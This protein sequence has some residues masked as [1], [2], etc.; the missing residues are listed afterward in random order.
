MVRVCGAA[1]TPCIIMNR[2]ANDHRRDT[3][4]LTDLRDLIE[5]EGALP[6]SRYMTL[7]LTHAQHGYYSTQRAI[8]AEGDFVTA[9]EISQIFGELIGLWAAVVWQ[10]MGAP[11]PLRLIELGPGR[12]TLMR[13]ALRAMDKIPGLA[14]ALVVDLVEINAT[15]RDAQ[16]AALA[17]TSTQKSWHVTLDAVPEDG[18][19]IVIGNEFLDTRPVEQFVQTEDGP[20]LRVVDVDPQGDLRFAT[21]ETDTVPP[22]AIRYLA[23][24]AVGTIV[25]VPADE[26]G[27]CRWMARR[28]D[29]PVAAL[30]IDYGHEAAAAGETL[31]AVR[32]H[33]FE[34]VLTS[35]GQA[36][37]SAQVDF[38]GVQVEAAR[39]NLSNDG[40]L[41]QAEFLGQLG[42]LERATRLM[43]ANP[44]RAAEIE[45]GVLRLMAPNG[46]GTRFKAIG[47]RRAGMPPLPGLVRPIAP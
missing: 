27:V 16:H 12:G 45:S 8:G 10:T 26:S 34:H 39:Y 2:P 18:A 4:L 36:D 21:R 42:I 38:S 30:L 28:Q 41:P 37:L 19:A 29:G 25:E 46:M 31:Q 47:L 3:P 33:Q 1:A 44:D 35:P 15:L 11:R 6:V 40:P 20:R 24:A 5:R 13:D 32:A 23:D 7:C 22:Q 17:G 43:N 9:P 14:E